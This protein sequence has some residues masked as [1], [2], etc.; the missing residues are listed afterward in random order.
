MVI[1]LLA[2]GFLLV[3][4][5]S[6]YLAVRQQNKKPLSTGELEQT[7]KFP[8]DIRVKRFKCTDCGAQLTM[9]NIKMVAGAPMVEC[10][11]CNANYQLTIGSK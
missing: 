7:V 4:S 6:I 5:L 11:Y 10:P 1:Y 3:I 8:E 2:G 9:D